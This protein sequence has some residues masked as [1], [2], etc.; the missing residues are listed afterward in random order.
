M[1]SEE[2]AKSFVAAINTG[3]PERVS[4]LMTED[5]IFVDADGTEYSGRD[6][7]REGWREYFSMVPD[8]RIEIGEVYSR[9][10]RVALTGIA[11]GT[12]S[13]GGEILPENHWRV[14]AAWWVGVRDGRVAVWQLYVNPEPM[15]E[16]LDRM[17]ESPR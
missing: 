7:M 4:E 2:V 1:T 3:D 16:I 11:E 12:F 5:H 6:R 14:P 9:G 10:D 17:R 15:R 8:F 13:Q